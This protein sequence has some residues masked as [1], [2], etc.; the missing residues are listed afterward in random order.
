[1]ASLQF[2]TDDRER[3]SYPQMGILRLDV[4]NLGS[5][6]GLGLGNLTS[7]SRIATLSRE[8]NLFFSGFIN[9]LAAKYKL[10]VT[11]SGGDDAFLIGSWYNVLHFAK[12]LHQDF[13]KFTCFNPDIT[14]SAGIFICDSNYPIAKFAEKA[15]ELEEQ[16]KNFIDP[17]T[18]QMKNAVTVFDHTLPWDKYCAMIDFAEKLLSY[19]NTEEARDKSKLA[20]S[21][22]HRILRLIK[23]CLDSK[24]KV[25]TNKLYRNVAQLHYLFAR[26]G[27]NEENIAKAQEG[28]AKDI[29]SLILKNFSQPGL[30]KDYLIPTNYVVLKTRKINK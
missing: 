21:L 12:E 16:S 25:D 2:D 29:I 11:Y 8:F 7:F 14:F 20:R 24:G 5:I 22:V 28:L 30:I 23:A 27:F 19:T 26:H 1:V 17:E 3:L 9:E 4:D 6:F 15:A 13:K 18:G 10:Y